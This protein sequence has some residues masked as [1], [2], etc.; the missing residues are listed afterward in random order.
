MSVK[1][2]KCLPSS[3]NDSTVIVEKVREKRVSVEKV[4]WLSQHYM[5]NRLLDERCL[6][7][8]VSTK[9]SSFSVAPTS[10]AS[11]LTL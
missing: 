10:L 2:R 9:P 5:Y 8:H 3:W 4:R 7:A 1:S 6:A 11:H